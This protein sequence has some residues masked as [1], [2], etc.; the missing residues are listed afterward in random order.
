[1]WI[2]VDPRTRPFAFNGYAGKTGEQKGAKTWALL[3]GGA[4]H[5]VNAP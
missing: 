5:P 1:V 3:I 4:V 2:D